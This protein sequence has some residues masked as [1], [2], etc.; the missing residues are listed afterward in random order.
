MRDELREVRTRQILGEVT[1]EVNTGIA[2][3]KHMA[4]RR[5][6]FV[7][8]DIQANVFFQ[9]SWCISEESRRENGIA[10]QARSVA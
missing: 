2:V 7:G 10:R 1:S 5:D 6:D 8:W 9:A 3:P 4:W